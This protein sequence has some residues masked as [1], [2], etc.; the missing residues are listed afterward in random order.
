MT[1][2]EQ[3]D[4][5]LLS[6]L[7]TNDLS[8]TQSDQHFEKNPDINLPNPKLIHDEIANKKTAFK[9]L[10]FLYLEQETRH[11]FLKQ[12]LDV[13]SNLDND[14]QSLQREADEGKQ[15]L[16]Q[17]KK[18][19]ESKIA[20][21]DT[22]TNEVDRQLQTFEDKSKDVKGLFDEFAELEKQIDN[23]LEGPH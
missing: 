22:L 1:D 3:I 15:G 7:D 18:G 16:Q 14:F 11:L 17:V 20:E 5:K 23:Q 6:I 10:K 21:L 9:K 2:H 8:I 13:K 4:A 19:L 12:V